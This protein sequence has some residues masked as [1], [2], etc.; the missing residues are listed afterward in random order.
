MFVLETLFDEIGYKRI[1]KKI[2]KKNPELSSLDDETFL[3][4]IIKKK[5]KETKW[6]TL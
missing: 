3:G 4:L 6:N 2:K 5:L 1:I